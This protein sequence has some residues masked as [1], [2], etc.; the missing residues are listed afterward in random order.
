[1]GGTGEGWGKR[2]TAS[3]TSFMPLSRLIIGNIGEW[4]MNLVRR[5]A[6]RPRPLAFVGSEVA[7]ICLFASVFRASHDSMI[8]E[9][10][11]GEEDHSLGGFCACFTSR[12]QQRQLRQWQRWR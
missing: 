1:M 6:G 2:P 10:K 9:G 7:L 12:W 4:G 8:E 11:R 3:V 5:R